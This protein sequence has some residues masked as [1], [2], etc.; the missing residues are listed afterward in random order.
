[1]DRV[2][3]AVEKTIG[4]EGRYANHPSDRGGETMWG[5]TEATARKHGYL[6][7]MRSLP[8]DVAVHIY[9]TE[10]YREPGFTWVSEFSES[11]AYRLFDAGVLC[12]PRKSSEW[13]QRCLN[14]FNKQGIIYA[15]L[16][17]DGIIGERTINALKS[18][19]VYRN[20][21]EPIETL[22][23]AFEALFG[24]YLFTIS[25]NIKPTLGREENEDFT[26]GWFR[27]RVRQ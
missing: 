11:L 23:E 9:V 15:D 6:G 16:T 27:H 4:K 26:Y 25:G 8:R 22:I 10:Y 2:L 21:Q 19:L 7:P 17:T 20:K 3:V 18:Y 12:G 24:H 1:M 14:L 13:L 5:I